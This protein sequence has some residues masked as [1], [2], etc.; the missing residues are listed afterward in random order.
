MIFFRS[1][2]ITPAFDYAA[3]ALRRFSFDAFIGLI[4]I[5]ADDLVDGLLLRHFSIAASMR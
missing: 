4:R 2:L 1:L 5:F 3:D